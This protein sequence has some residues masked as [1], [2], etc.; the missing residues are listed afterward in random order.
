MQAIFNE[1]ISFVD[2]I[3]LYGGNEITKPNRGFKHD[4]SFHSFGVNHLHKL[5]KIL[6]RVPYAYNLRALLDI[7][8]CTKLNPNKIFFF[9]KVEIY[10][11]YF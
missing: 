10:D 7:K 5:S 8:V 6:L 2:L 1:F 11:I 9:L 4:M 3:D